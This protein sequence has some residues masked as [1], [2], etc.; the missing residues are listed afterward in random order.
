MLRF[1]DLERVLDALRLEE[2][3][4]VSRDETIGVALRLGG[5]RQAPVG[6]VSNRPRL[7]RGDGEESGRLDQAEIRPLGVDAELAQDGLSRE[8]VLL[9]FLEDR[10]GPRSRAV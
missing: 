2:E 7:S 6:L 10:D 4:S 9:E 8:D 1:K 3:R 5:D